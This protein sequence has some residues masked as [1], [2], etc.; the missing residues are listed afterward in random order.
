MKFK[1]LFFMFLR[2][3]RYAIISVYVLIIKGTTIIKH[4]TYKILIIMTRVYSWEDRN[5][6]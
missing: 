1:K 5:K 4:I 3:D 6:Q 2:L